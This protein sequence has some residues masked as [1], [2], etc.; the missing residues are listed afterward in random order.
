M[1]CLPSVPLL[2]GNVEAPRP[3]R[4]DLRFFESRQPPTN[5]PV[6]PGRQVK[7]AA[8]VGEDGDRIGGEVGWLSQILWERAAWYTKIPPTQLLRFLLYYV[9]VTRRMDSSIVS[10]GIFI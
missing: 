2:D 9:Q 5:S 4:L 8:G 3:H 7:C 1:W 6:R 10:A